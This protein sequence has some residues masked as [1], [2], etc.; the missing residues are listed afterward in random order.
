[1][2]LENEL[3]YGIYD[4]FPVTEHHALVVTKRHVPSYFDLGRPEVNACNQ[5]LAKLRSDISERDET[6]SAF[7]VPVC[8]RRVRHFSPGN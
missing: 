7:N 5:L 1:M 4:A 6:V 2:I 8:Q 3:A